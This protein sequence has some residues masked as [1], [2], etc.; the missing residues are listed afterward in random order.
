MAGA[1]AV[2]ELLKAKQMTQA[3][4]AELLGVHVSSLKTYLH[5][6]GFSVQMLLNICDVLGVRLAFVNGDEVIFI[7]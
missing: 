7:D 2:R 5:R 6:D 4:L 3:R 1:K